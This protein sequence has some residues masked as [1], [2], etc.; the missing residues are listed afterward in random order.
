MDQPL[1]QEIDGRAEWRAA[2]EVG[3]AAGGDQLVIEQLV[4]DIAG[5]AAAAIADQDVHILAAGDIEEAVGDHMAHIDLRPRQVEGG[6]AR[7]QPEESE[8]A[9]GADGHLLAA[10]GRTKLGDHRGDAAET[11]AHRLLQPLAL[12]RQT[13]GAMQAV[14]QTA[15][16]ILFQ[17][18]DL[19]AQSR[20]RDLQ[21]PRR[22]LEGKVARGGLESHQAVG[23]RQAEM[24]RS[25]LEILIEAP[26]SFQFTDAGKVGKLLTTP[27]AGRRCAE[28]ARVR[29]QG[30]A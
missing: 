29:E 18:P 1:V 24:S 8:R 25:H 14:E 4:A 27:K 12:R 13:D 10:I 17:D 22:F 15:S 16:Q 30:K 23:R 28:P 21:F 6:D 2:L 9:G 7:Q 5:Q 20:G 26:Q 19:P 3:R 11:G